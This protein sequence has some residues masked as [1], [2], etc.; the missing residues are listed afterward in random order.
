MSLWLSLCWAAVSG[1][2]ICE[3]Y[4]HGVWCWDGVGGM[5]ARGFGSGWLVW[6]PIT[7]TFTLCYIETVGWLTCGGEMMR[8]MV[9]I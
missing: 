3:A 1:G 6:I 5:A 7:F 4:V 9:K 2:I 8:V